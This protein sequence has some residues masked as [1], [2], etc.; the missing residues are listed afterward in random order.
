M[1][2][3]EYLPTEEQESLPPHDLQVEKSILGAILTDP[4]LL[5]DT[6]VKIKAG[7]KAFYHL[8]HQLIYE[9]MLELFDDDISIDAIT[10]R[11]RLAVWGKLDQI[12]GDAYLGHIQDVLTSTQNLGDW[13]GIL[14][15]KFVIRN[16][17]RFCAETQ[18]GAYAVNG[19]A[20]KFLAQFEQDALAIR[21]SAESVNTF[22][23][24]RSTIDSLIEDYNNAATNQTAQGIQTGFADLDRLSGGL[25]PQ[26]LIILAGLRST[27]KTTLALNIA[28]NMAE[29][30]VGVGIV[31]LETSGKKLIHRLACYSG[32]IS[33]AE[34][35]RGEN[36]DVNAPKVTAA[37]GKIV[38]FS[39]NIFICERGDMSSSE[40]Q[41]VCRRMHQKGARVFVVDY[42]QLLN[43]PG[44]SEYDKITAASKFGK[45][46]AKTLN[47]PVI[48]IS[49]LN[50]ESEKGQKPRKPRMSD[51]R[52]SGQIEYDADKAWLLYDPEF[53]DDFKNE[54]S[55][56]V[57]L[58]FAKNKDGP[59]GEIT[60]TFFPRQ[61][62]MT[63][64]ARIADEDV[65]N[66]PQLQV[67]Y[68]DD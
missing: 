52:S 39:Q 30:G 10:L 4:T 2:A 28:Y 27:G 38:S 12:G 50:R 29:Q 61:F 54:E 14:I 36:V 24:I 21:G 20:E 7:A 18:Q 58:N 8:P 35:L 17:I 37:M 60:L 55:R 40:L 1:Q 31:S 59:T 3:D 34:L 66:N 33:G 43:C 48:L 46:L 67:P 57:C 11:E 26:E 41:A 16:V 9:T 6:I 68:A 5:S 64:A 32:Q 56:N 62:R 63:S 13:I 19:N 44:K 42:M 45:R 25:M 22:V 49:A 51:F 53:R 65:Q 47:C 15:G 23:N